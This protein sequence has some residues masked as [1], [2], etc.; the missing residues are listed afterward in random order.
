MISEARTK[1]TERGDRGDR[2]SSFL[3]YKGTA[4]EGKLE[5]EFGR[6]RERESFSYL[7]YRD[8]TTLCTSAANEKTNTV[9]I[10]CAAVAVLFLTWSSGRFSSGTALTLRT[11]GQSRSEERMG[12]TAIDRGAM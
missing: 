3:R 6:E 10:R 7:T 12:T 5:R 11:V 9:A 1:E 2:I 4:M 8:G